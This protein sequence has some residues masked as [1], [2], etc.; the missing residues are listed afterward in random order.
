MR[1]DAAAMRR[2]GQHQ[3]IEP[4]VGHEAKARQQLMRRI[5]V[6]IQ[7][8]H[9][10]RPA[11]TRQGRQRAARQRPLAHVPRLTALLDEP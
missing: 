4:C 6:Q 11:V 1:P 2:I 9:E 3:I 5:V 8:L 10:Q 7:P